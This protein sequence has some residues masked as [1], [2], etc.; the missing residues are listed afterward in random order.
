MKK[1]I[2]FVFL[3]SS[4]LFAAPKGLELLKDFP[5]KWTRL[6]THKGARVVYRYCSADTP[7]VEITNREGKNIMV[8]N[9]GQDADEVE[10][11][12]VEKTNNGLKFQFKSLLYKDNK[13]KNLE[14]AYVGNNKKI[15]RWKGSLESFWQDGPEFVAEPYQK[16]FKEIIEPRKNCFPEG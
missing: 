12:G 3:I 10:L 14:F 2:L 13:V 9:Y 4:P 15:G 6:E 1:L 7:T 16:E 8:F 11:L 5:Q